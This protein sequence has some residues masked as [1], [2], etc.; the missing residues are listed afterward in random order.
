MGTAM[1]P[2]SPAEHSAATGDAPGGGFAAARADASWLG[3]LRHRLRPS[4]GG[5]RAAR[6]LFGEILDW[7]FAP[8]LLLWPISVSITYLVAQ[9]I[10]TTPYDHALIDRADALAAR[11]RFESGRAAFDLS[12]GLLETYGDGTREPDTF[13][14]ADSDGRVLAG[15]RAL[16]RPRPPGA[17]RIAEGDGR[18][19]LR[20][21]TLH[22]HAVR[23]AYG[24]LVPP[25][26]LAP[27]VLV[28]AA[29][30]PTERTMLANEIIKGVIVPQ[31][32]VL[33]LALVLV[34]FGL[35]RGL[36]PL[37]RLQRTIR[38]RPPEDLSPID[39]EA[40]PEELAPLLASFNELLA[41]MAHSLDV[42]KRFIADAAH[43]MKTPLAGLRTQAELAQREVDANELQRSLRQI[44]RS[45]ERATRMVNQLL[46]LARAEHAAGGGAAMVRVDL[47]RLARSVVQD[48]VAQAVAQ[49]TDLGYEGPSGDSHILGAPMLLREL[50]NNL[51]DNAMHYGCA[52][53]AGGAV[54]VRVRRE[55]DAVTL[56]VEDTG[57]GIAPAE[58]TRVFERFYRV[59]GSQSDGSG[60]GLAIVREITAQHRATLQLGD[61]QIGREPPAAGPGAR[62][63][64]R[65]EHAANEAV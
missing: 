9:S 47:D 54:T 51:I 16:A 59:L 29:E 28:E 40:A 21:D 3:A 17:E 60:L 10:A 15:D 22:G 50:L 8:L 61:A 36:A 25:G 39:A 62:F 31:F 46:A 23:V 35:S 53:G 41:R 19:Q 33:P 7:M 2:A 64:V 11:V 20:D 44:A 13:V 55:D 14:V 32:V 63:T 27:A 24:W 57:P 43:Q 48:W 6:S 37:A 56:E 58:R 45:S 12:P 4:P 1:P 34:W 18:F 26:G 42:Q 65:F 52:P 49:G 30:P 38:E 5:E